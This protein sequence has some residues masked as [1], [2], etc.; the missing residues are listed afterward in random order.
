[1]S[2]PRLDRIAANFT[3]VQ[4]GKTTVWFSYETIVAYQDGDN[5]IVVRRN[6]W[7]TTTGKH[8]NYID[9]GSD[10]AKKQRPASGEFERRLEVLFS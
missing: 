2:M 1:M 4:V 8:L 7:S 9:G 3:R 5:A 10:A 6:D